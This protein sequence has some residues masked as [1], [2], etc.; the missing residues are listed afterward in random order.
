MHPPVRLRHFQLL[1]GSL[2]KDEVIYG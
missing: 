1:P 2:T